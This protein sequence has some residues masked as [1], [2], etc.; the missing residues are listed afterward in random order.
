MNAWERR[1]IHMTVKE[2]EGILTESEDSG[3]GR[4]VRIKPEEEQG[5]G[6]EAGE[7]MEDTSKEE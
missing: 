5:D 7:G 1:I 4:R 6:A 3:E 2:K